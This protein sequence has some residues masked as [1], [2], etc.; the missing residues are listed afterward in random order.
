M[1]T[2]AIGALVL[3]A[4]LAVGAC[5]PTGTVTPAPLPTP[6][7]SPV[8][9]V[10]PSAP[11]TPE[12]TPPASVREDESLLA[13]LPAEV[14]DVPVLPEPASFADA[15]TFPDFVANVEAAAFAI[16]VRDPDLASGV[17]ARLRP[18]VFSDGFYRDWRDSYDEGACSQA[19]GVAGRAE[20]QLGGRTVFI[21]TCVGGLVVYHTYLPERDVV[22]SVFSIGE[23]RLG[24]RIMAELRP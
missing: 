23:R 13:I 20:A 10:D 24:E 14:D 5:A 15:V 6:V 9:T 19:G 17:V 2:L 16:A 11:V 21:A 8:A 22:V 7:H 1:R 18:G 12:P 3:L 4:I